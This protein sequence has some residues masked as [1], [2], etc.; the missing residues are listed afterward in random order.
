MKYSKE[1]FKRDGFEGQRAIVVPKSILQKFCI[2]NKLINKCYI[3]DIGYYPKAR[4]HFRER[5]HGAEQNILIYC[6]DGKGTIKVKNITYNMGSGDFVFIPKGQSHSYKT[7]PDNPWTIYWCHFKGEQADEIIEISF[8]KKGSPKG[9]VTFLDTRINLFDSIYQTLESGY[10]FDNLSYVN[11]RFPQ[12][13]SSFLF[14]DKFEES[15]KNSSEDIIEL[16][17][18]YMQ[19]NLDK[20]LTLAMIA[21]SVNTSASHFLSVFKKRTGFP[22]IEYFNHLKIQKACQFL[23]FTPLRIKEIAFKI[24]LDDQY[25][26]SRLFTKVMGM[27]PTEYREQR[28]AAK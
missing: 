17:F 24:G 7:D 22:P 6:V 4:L 21:Q 20:P 9:Y 23:Q 11:L 28:S 12:F 25:Y 26:F 27:S 14:S 8:Q 5:P 16:S 2:S 13:L 3:T 15:P 19:D 10:G 18:R 1:N